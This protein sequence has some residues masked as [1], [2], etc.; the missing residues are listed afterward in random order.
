M[1]FLLMGLSIFSDGLKTQSRGLTHTKLCDRLDKTVK[2]ENTR[3]LEQGRRREILRPL[4]PE[5]RCWAR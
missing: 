2:I 3:E 5:A 1:P 4:I